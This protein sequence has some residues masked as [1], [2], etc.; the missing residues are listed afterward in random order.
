MKVI[1]MYMVI[2]CHTYPVT[3]LN[4]LNGVN[5]Q[6]FFFISGYLVK[7]TTWRNLI[8][9]STVYMLLPVTIIVMIRACITGYGDVP[10][11]DIIITS[12]KNCVLGFNGYEHGVYGLYEAW[13]VYTLI[14][15]LYLYKGLGLKW[16]TIVTPLMVVSGIVMCYYNKSYYNSVADAVF[17]APFFV[18]GAWVRKYSDKLGRLRD[19]MHIF[20]RIGM[21]AVCATLYVLLTSMNGI[22]RLF[23]NQ[24]GNYIVLLYVDAF[25]GIYVIYEIA[26]V[27][28]RFTGPMVAKFMTLLASGNLIV[29]CT[30]YP[31]LMSTS[32]WRSM[33]YSAVLYAMY[34]PVIWLAAKYAPLFIGSRKRRNLL[35]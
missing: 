32:G 21:V 35:S 8:I 3:I 29:L 27:C 13:F 15:L 1:G 19:R 6:L 30:H 22:P 25:L 7:P 17:C 10:M 33:V 16:F 14:V 5:V 26:C 4:I 31:L 9:K 28:Q 20:I 11:T 24:Y 34:I 12:F 23:G 2:L 18:G